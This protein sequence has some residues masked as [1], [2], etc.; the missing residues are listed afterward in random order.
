MNV[1][2]EEIDCDKNIH[3]AID[4]MKSSGSNELP[5]IKYNERDFIVGYDKNNLEKLYKLY[6]N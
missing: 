5:I 3:E 4:I 1:K 6:K 2:Y